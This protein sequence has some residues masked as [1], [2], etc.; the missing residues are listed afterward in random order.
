MNDVERVKLVCKER[1]IPI[2]KL[3]KELGFANG[4]IGQL[5]KGFFPSDRAAKIS[6]FLGI[7]LTGGSHQEIT[8]SSDD[9]ARDDSERR[10]LMLCRKA[11]DANPDEK[12]ALVDNFEATIDIYLR[13]KGLKKE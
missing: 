2:S 3:E 9:I 10:L 13:A 5:K 4:Y 6:S 12:E 1:K 7:E 11:V 8:N